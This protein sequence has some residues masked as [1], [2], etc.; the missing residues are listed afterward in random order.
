VQWRLAEAMQRQLRRKPQ[1]ASNTFSMEQVSLKPNSFCVLIV[2]CGNI[3][4]QFDR[5]RSKDELP[6]THAGAYTIDGRFNLSACVEPDDKRRADFMAAWRV[7]FGFRSIEDA[8]NSGDRFDVI[9]ICSPTASHARDLEVAVRAMP[10]LIFCE[11][12]LATSLADAERLVGECRKNNILLAVNYSRRFDPDVWK[13][14]ADI[15]AGRWGQLRSIVGSYNKGI[16]NNGSHML[17]LT[18]LLVGPMDIMKVGRPIYDFYPSDPTVPAWLEGA[19]ALSVQLV[20]GHAVDYALFELQL[21]FSQGALA[22]EE[23]G[24]FWRERRVVDSAT[25]KGYRVLDD[26]VRRAGRYPQSMLQAVGNIYEAI[27]EG[28]PLASTGE[29]ALAAQRMC[30]QIMR[31]ACTQ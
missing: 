11:K 19:D 25:F 3:A 28:K 16:L 4:G 1:K 22:M 26:G 29:T 30:E 14:Q 12:P 27:M 18:H 2:G 20:C 6:Y 15:Q 21:L 13:L 10:K 5:S 23:G 9:S 31:Q 7:P 24:M 17:D 8:V